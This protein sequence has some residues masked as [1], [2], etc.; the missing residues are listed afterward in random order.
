MIKSFCFILFVLTV[1]LGTADARFYVKDSVSLLGGIDT[2]SLYMESS[3]GMDYFIRVDPAVSLVLDKRELLFELGGGIDYN[4]YFKNSS[5]SFFAWTFNGDLELKPDDQTAFY[6]T[7][8]YTNNSDPVLMDTEVRA[9]WNLY[10]IGAGIDYYTSS[11]AWQFI[12][13]INADSKKYEESLFDNFDNKKTYINIE[14]KYYFF[15]ES[16]LRLGVIGGRSYYTSG[17][18]TRPYGNSDSVY[19]EGFTGLS[20]RLVENINIETKVGFLWMDYQHG[21]SFHEPIIIIKVTD[22][23]SN[24]TSLSAE[25]ERM[26]YDSVY[27]NFYVDEKVAMS[28]KSIWYD[29]IVNLSTFQYIYRYYRGDPKRVDHRLGFI[30]ESSIPLFVVAALK[31]NISLTTTFLAEWVNSDAYNSFAYYV[32]PDPSAS[33]SRMVFML[34][35]TNKF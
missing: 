16:A 15:P 3:T 11:K 26:A 32:G 28:F 20:G 13:G 9:K 27:S 4:H 18:D 5:Q 35:L 31:E 7:N 34:G 29:S 14:T 12:S 2:N 6:I 33:Y 8:S 19:I 17:Y 23:L 21:L 25:Y 10:T 24:R 30:T 22:I 1:F